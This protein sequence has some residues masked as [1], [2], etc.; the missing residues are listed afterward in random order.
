MGYANTDF[1]RIFESAPGLYLVLSPDLHIVAVSDAYLSATM[2]SRGD[3]LGKYLFVVFPDNPD[4]TEA[5]GVHNLRHS[6]ESV[7]RDKRSNTMAIQKYDIRRPESEGGGF[8]ERYWSPINSPVLDDDGELAYIIHRVEDVTEYVRL[9]ARAEAESTTSARER[10]ESDI[11]LYHR[12]QEIQNTNQRLAEANEALRISEENALS[13]MNEL[14]ISNKELESFSYSVSHDLRA[15][16]RAISGFSEILLRD[17]EGKLSEDDIFLFNRIILATRRMSDLVDALLRLARTG[18]DQ[19]DVGTV[20]LSAIASEAVEEVSLR[21]SADEA[22][23]MVEQ[24]L[25]ARGDVRLLRILIDN[26]VSNAF[27]F[28]AKVEDPVIAFC[29]KAIDGETVYCVQDNGIGFDPNLAEKV[30]EP[31]QRAHTEEEFKGTGIGLAICAKIVS[32]HGGR[33]WAESAVGQGTT[34]FFT[35]NF[36]ED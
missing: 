23:A 28:S 1:K 17:L 36:R 14:K 32:R 19:M 30:F 26:L 16:L 15:P 31:F 5:T 25:T 10:Q 4:D 29:S 34:I 33:I 18:R 7:L 9:M 8:E 24:G 22:E 35:L 13:L 27:K 3:I 2:T 11:E 6:L 12:A 21:H 20:D